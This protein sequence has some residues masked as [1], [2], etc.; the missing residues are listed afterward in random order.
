M[1]VACIIYSAVWCLDSDRPCINFSIFCE[2][3]IFTGWPVRALLPCSYWYKLTLR[4]D[5]PVLIVAH[6]AGESK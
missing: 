3:T 5:R 6:E 4:M 2:S 1:P